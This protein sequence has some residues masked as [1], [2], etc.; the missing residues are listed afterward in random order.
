MHILTIVMYI[1]KRHGGLQSLEKAHHPNP[2]PLGAG[3]EGARQNQ[4]AD[5]PGYTPLVVVKRHPA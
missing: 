5:A 3:Q 4:R 1:G 2:L